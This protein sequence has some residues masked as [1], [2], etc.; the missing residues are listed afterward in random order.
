MATAAASSAATAATVTP[1]SVRRLRAPSPRVLSA[2]LTSG[3]PF[4]VEGATTLWPAASWT[5]TTLRSPPFADRLVKV[6]LHRRS[7][8]E[9][10]APAD[11][12]CR[13]CS[14]RSE[15][16]F[17]LWASSD[18][19]AACGHNAGVVW[20]GDCEFVT[21]TLG[22]F[23]EWLHSATADAGAGS[24][25]GAGAGAGSGSGTGAARRANTLREYDRRE[26]WGY[27]D[28]VHLKALFA[29][30]ETGTDAAAPDAD[31]LHAASSPLAEA[32]R[33]LPW[34][35]T[36]GAGAP[37]DGMESTLWVGSDGACTPVS[38]SCTV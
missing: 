24:G 29:E 1:K 15:A 34:N 7:S 25:A 33:A 30:R 4:V 21:T 22:M 17:A 38:L 35:A 3:E 10:A 23:C 14:A 9:D 11:A 6:R 20:E 12:P 8:R 28:Y 2:A 37:A 5:T 32:A 36:F 16:A 19:R 18:S 31:G 26:W 13:C 27:V